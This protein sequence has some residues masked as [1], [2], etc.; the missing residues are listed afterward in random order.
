MRKDI[1]KKQYIS[2]FHSIKG[3]VE[4]QTSVGSYIAY[5]ENSIDLSCS[6][7]SLPTAVVKL[8]EKEVFGVG[9]FSVGKISAVV[10]VT[11]QVE[12]GSK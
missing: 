4:N 9:Q 1:C 3:Q 8:V 6:S 12:Y 7:T 5:T 10:C 11:L 2:I